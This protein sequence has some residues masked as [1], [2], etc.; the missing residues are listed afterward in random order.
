MVLESCDDYWNGNELNT[1]TE[2]VEKKWAEFVQNATLCDTQMYIPD[3]YE[4]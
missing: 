2:S 1:I 4:L 3:V